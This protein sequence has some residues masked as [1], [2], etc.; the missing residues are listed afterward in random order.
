ME[1]VKGVLLDIN[2]V[3]E[4]GSE[5]APVAPDAITFLRDKKS[6]PSKFQFHKKTRTINR[7]KSR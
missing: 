4:V 3:H 6:P 7:Q 1:V 2:G 5:P